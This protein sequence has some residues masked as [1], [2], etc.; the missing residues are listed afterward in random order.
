MHQTAATA[1]RAEIAGQ[2]FDADE[3]AARGL[4]IVVENTSDEVMQGAV[5]RVPLPPRC[6][7]SDPDGLNAMHGL[8]MGLDHALCLTIDRLQP[9]DSLVIVVALRTH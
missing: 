7:L 3:L 2:G 1:D 6:T 9:H 5:V 4:S 8:R